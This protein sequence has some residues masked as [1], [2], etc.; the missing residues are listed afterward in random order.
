M[1]SCFLRDT[2]TFPILLTLAGRSPTRPPVA[3]TRGADDD[4]ALAASKVTCSRRTP[5]SGFVQTLGVQLSTKL[6]LGIKPLEY[7]GR[8]G[9]APVSAAKGA[10]GG[11]A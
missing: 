1:S 4:L 11:D 6:A 8:A 2:T 7:V 3:S 10:W 9:S 5:L